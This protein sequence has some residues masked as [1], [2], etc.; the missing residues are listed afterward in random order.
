MLNNLH[1]EIYNKGSL[2][3]Q[4][5]QQRL[6]TTSKF[7]TEIFYTIKFATDIKSNLIKNNIT[8]KINNKFEGIGEERQLMSIIVLVMVVISI[9]P[10][11]KIYL[12]LYCMRVCA[13]CA[14]Q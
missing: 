9:L 7:T 13:T 11:L 3:H 8:K 6:F 10:L 1:Q 12:S 14:I 2:H 5:L 4:N